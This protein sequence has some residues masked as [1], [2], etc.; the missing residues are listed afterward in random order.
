MALLKIIPAWVLLMACLTHAHLVASSLTPKGGETL[1]VNQPVT[2]TWNAEE[3]HPDQGTIDLAYSKDG[4]ITW[5]S[6]KAGILDTEKS[7]T[8]RWLTG[9][10]E[11]TTQAKVRVCQIGPCGT[12]NVSKPQGAPPWYMVSGVFTVQAATGLVST[13]ESGNPISLDFSPATRNV[14]VSLSLATSQAVLLQAFD[15]QGRLVATLLQGNYAAGN[16]A[17]SVF[18]NR[19]TAA[20]ESLV[21]R[22]K[23]GE[24]IRTHTWM[25]LR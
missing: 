7:N 6:I 18:S 4:G 5:T 24:Q 8:F 10:S 20:N 22:L 17:F 2:I 11:A 23:V 3:N 12:L 14:E 25:V 21:F 16:H 13:S 19:V 9:P 1:T 15:M